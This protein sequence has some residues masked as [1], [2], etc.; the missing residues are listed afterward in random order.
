[1]RNTKSGLEEFGYK[2]P[3]RI[4]HAPSVNLDG[5]LSR[6]ENSVERYLSEAYGRT[7]AALMGDGNPNLGFAKSTY[8]QRLVSSLAAS[9]ASLRN[10]RE[11]LST[12][13]ERANAGD[14]EILQTELLQDDD[15]YE[16]QDSSEVVSRSAVEIANALKRVASEAQIELSYLDDLL[17]MFSNINDDIAS[18]DPK[19]NVSIQLLR[20]MV[21]TRKVLVFSKYT[22]TIDS[23]VD[24]YKSNNAG[25]LQ[26]GI[27]QYTGKSVWIERDEVRVDATKAEVVAALANDDVRVIFCSDAASEGLNLQSANVLINLDVPWNPARLEQRIGRIA[28]LG[29]TSPTVDI[30]NLW[31]PSSI[32]AK[33]YS[34]LL[35]RRDEYQLAVGE[36]P[37]IFSESI[38]REIR[39]NLNGD[40]LPEVDPIQLLSEARS[41]VQRIALGKLWSVESEGSSISDEFRNRMLGVLRKDE[42]IR[43]SS[44]QLTEVPGCRN[45]LTP[46][47]E[48]LSGLD[49]GFHEVGNAKVEAVIIDSVPVGL[50]VGVDDGRNY[51]LKPARFPELVNSLLFGEPLI[52]SS[53]I[54]ISTEDLLSLTIENASSWMP[55][56]S[57]QTLGVLHSEKETVSLCDLGYVNVA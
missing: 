26:F 28:R 53:L 17:S 3:D 10:R 1:V 49:F 52:A 54:E 29:Q 13:R 36:F 43:N 37:E 18:Y 40:Q 4:F 20:E 32:E 12:I 50:K 2:F 24:F 41:T 9:Y 5:D 55:N 23:F 42:K 15:E 34:R 16:V 35:E 38:S 44:S 21:P 48:E 46:W 27:A 8:Y 14:V 31:Y 45:S 39:V 19:F 25:L 47:S 22:D 6:F 7:E 33:M 51:L 11:K 56:M 30:F 57:V